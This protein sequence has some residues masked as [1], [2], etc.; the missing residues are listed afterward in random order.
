MT[1]T[2]HTPAVAFTDFKR[3]ACPALDIDAILYKGQP[4]PNRQLIEHRL[5]WNL[6]RF[7]AANDW[8]VCRL[9]DGDDNH[10]FKGD[11]DKRIKAAMEMVFNLDE[12]TMLFQLEGSKKTHTVTIILG[13]D[14]WD[15]I[16]DHTYS[17]ND[18]DNFGAVMEDFDC[19]SFIEAKPED[20]APPVDADGVV[21]GSA[22]HLV[23]WFA[24][25]YGDQKLIS[26]GFERYRKEFPL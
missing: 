1:T 14:G 22:E 2:K 10:N 20:F 16:A 21:V 4:L 15:A 13:N 5:V 11:I 3:T 7:L 9:Y 25:Q 19:E 8:I 17:A 18:S 6:L 12:C 26:Y 24:R 23:K